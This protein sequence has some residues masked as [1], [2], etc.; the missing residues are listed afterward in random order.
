MAKRNKLGIGLDIGSRSI[1]L[2]VL[3]AKRG[4]VSVE[5]IASKELPHDAIVE[6]VV[7]DTDAVCSRIGELLKENQVKGREIAISVGGRRVMIKRVATDEMSEEELSATIA[8]EARTNLPYD[9][10]EL[11]LDYARLPQ[12]PDTGRMGVL[13]VA[14]KNEVVG[15]AVDH[16]RWA[17]GHPVLLE[18]EP[19]ALQAA[20]TE[21][22]YL[23][24]QGTVAV[25]QL[26]FQTT[27]VT[28][29]AGGVYDTNRNLNVGGKIYV[30]ELIREMGIP[31][32]RAAAL[33]A[34]AER[35]LDETE[36]LNRVA[37]RV[38]EKIAE[39]IER[40]FPEYF[41]L[42]AENPLSRIMLCGGGAHLP[43]LEAAL[44]ER[45][46]I[47]VI[48]CDPF[49]RFELNPKTVD[50]A[51][52]AASAPDFAA[53]VGLA[54]RLLDDSHPGF[55]LL[56]AQDRPEHRKVKYAGLGT[57]LPIM[58]FSILLFGMVMVYLSQEGALDALGKRLE[59]IRK[60]A[61]LYQD[62]I[63]LVESLSR[64]RADIAARMDVISRLDRN[65][66]ARIRLLQLINNALPELTWI[67]DVQE[68][69]TP[70]GPGAKVMGV[71]SSNLKVSEF[72]S[73]LL[74]SGSV[75]GVDLLVSEQTEIG[76]ANVTRFT[77]QIAMGDLGI[78]EQKPPENVDL[79]KRGAQ[80][81][82][83]RR[84]AEEDLKKQTGK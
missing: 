69:A 16:L 38:S 33:L 39:Q 22:G 23:E 75:T 82:R 18:A 26:G 34:A 58:G 5:R 67:T 42:G 19:F 73:N 68:S 49:Q 25:L 9:I 48:V 13:L 36:V 37:F 20:L 4:S 60:E 55:N 65:R 57:V 61:S 56:L 52:A 78:Q 14:A 6:G 11:S 47:E 29:F 76:H 7:M 44:R 40:S 79:L 12:D 62:K 1:Q 63:E 71:T 72:M 32:E 77:L 81:I 80:A 8:Y 35:S 59:G 10:K 70:R 41:G 30:E 64:K 53:A 27:D 45:F 3:R 15:D 21:A 2:A 50:P 46:G 54:L 17:G 24:E 51:V 28:L 83:E 84:A 66:F 74:R 31:F 43:M